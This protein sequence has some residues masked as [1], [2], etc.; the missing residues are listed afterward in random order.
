MA[1]KVYKIEAFEGGVNQKNDPRDIKNNELKEA[2][3]VNVSNLGRITMPGDGKSYYET[4]N[5]KNINV[6]PSFTEVDL[7]DEGINITP[8]HGLFSFAHDYNMATTP[9]LVDTEFICIND[10]AYI[11][12]WDDCHDSFGNDAWL[13]QKIKLGPVNSS[14]IND[15]EVSTVKP[16]YYKADMGLRVCDGNFNEIDTGKNTDTTETASDTTIGIEDGIN[17]TVSAGDYIKINSEIMKVISTALG[18]L[19]VVRGQFNTTASSHNSGSDVYIINVP[20]I[21]VH[22]YRTMLWKLETEG[23]ITNVWKEDIQCLEPPNNYNDY[24][25]VVFDGKVTGMATSGLDGTDDLAQLSQEPNSP[26]KVLFSI[27]ESNSADDNIITGTSTVDGSLINNQSTIKVNVSDGISSSFATGK[28]IIVSHSQYIDGLHEILSVNSDTQMQVSGEFDTAE[29]EP[30]E[31]RLEE[32]KIDGDLQNK[33]IFGMSFLYDGGDPDAM[34]ESSI[35][36]GY[37]YSGLIAHDA[38]VARNVNSDWK[39]DDNADDSSG[40]VVLSEVTD[41]TSTPGSNLGWVL[42]NNSLYYDVSA[43]SADDYLMYV[44]SGVTIATSTKY[45]ISIDVTI[46]GAGELTIYPPGFNSANNGTVGDDSDTSVIITSTGT[47]LLNAVSS[48][49]VLSDQVFVCEAH[50]SGGDI[51]INNVNV[52]LADD[53]NGP[54]EMDANNAIDIRGWEGIPKIFSSFNMNQHENYLWNERIAGYKIYMKQVDSVSN[55]LID[56]WLLTLKVDFASGEYTNYSNDALEKTL[57][58]EDD[59]VYNGTTFNGSLVATIK[60]SSNSTGLSDMDTMRNIPIDTY[61]SENEYSADTVTSAMYKTSAMVN[62]KMF[63]GNLKIGNNTYPDRML[64]AP[65]DKYDTFPN[66]G[67][68]NIEIAVGD[69]DEIVK[70]ESL[71]NQLIQFKKKYVYVI[72]ILDEGL[73]LMHTWPNAGIKLPCQ[74]IQ[75]SGGIAWVNDNGLYY[76]DG[77]KLQM[78]TKDKF[79]SQ[80]WIINEDVVNATILGYDAASDKIIIFTSNLSTHSSGGYLYDIKAGSVTECE[81]LFNW[82]PVETTSINIPSGDI[83]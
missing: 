23:T 33:Y 54:V 13:K 62:R 30:F 42:Y 78:I 2:F 49:T 58:L 29:S 15:T 82:Y 65:R 25:L 26:E 28:F 53:T 74:S 50:T 6:G 16:V 38:S 27:H 52:F 57:S 83:E 56:E 5:A 18:S 55:V 61:Q 12:I 39:R 7:F 19:T 79:N 24:G 44:N 77:D 76:Y 73:E 11:H 14:N 8:G 1:K 9:L 31:I 59:W 68:H 43:T 75:A 70:L 45:K 4:L 17:V 71:G 46:H 67:F 64:E 37:L 41:L 35:R 69:G 3:N 36:P 40:A 80:S 34:Q 72:N 63:I 32:D 81:N 48:G 51:Q 10:G 21:L 66:D 22:I 47:Y 20:K 60:D